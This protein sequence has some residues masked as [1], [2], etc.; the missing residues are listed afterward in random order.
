MQKR[1][2]TISVGRKRRGGFGHAC[3]ALFSTGVGSLLALLFKKVRWVVLGHDCLAPTALRAPTPGRKPQPAAGIK[4][5]AYTGS[6]TRPKAPEPGETP[7]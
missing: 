5:R 7:G 4:S 3:D 1:A 6:P 2:R